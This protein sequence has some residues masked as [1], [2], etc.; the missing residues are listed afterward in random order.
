MMNFFK[1]GD[2]L[3]LVDM[4]GYGWKSR[5]EWG[6]MILDYLKMRKKYAGDP[7]HGTSDGSV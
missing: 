7:C 5:D 6:G 1:V 4:P 2:K 3:S